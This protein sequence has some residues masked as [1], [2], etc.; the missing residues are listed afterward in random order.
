[1]KFGGGVIQ[2]QTLVTYAQQNKDCYVPP[3]SPEAKLLLR[4]YA[5]EC[6]KLTDIIAE[7]RGVY[8][9]GRYDKKGLWRN[10]YLGFAGE[11]K[12]ACLRARFNEELR[13][14]WTFPARDC[15]EREQ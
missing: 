6:R 11:G 2:L 10:I 12:T 5:N 15:R 4:Y 8:L 9:W 7:A 3:R 1:M 13:V 14:N